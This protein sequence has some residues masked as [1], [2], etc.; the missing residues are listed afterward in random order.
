M[1]TIYQQKPCSNFI[2]F[3]TKSKLFFTYVY[4]FGNILNSNFKHIWIIIGWPNLNATCNIDW[5]L[6][7]EYF[8][9]TQ[10]FY[11]THN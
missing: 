5:A 4:N 8:S 2:T 9:N 1:F 10:Y 6:V 3:S 11:R 7:S